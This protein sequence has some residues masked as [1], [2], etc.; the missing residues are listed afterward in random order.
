MD[1]LAEAPSLEPFRYEAQ[2]QHWLAE[3]PDLLEPGLW[4]VAGELELDQVERHRVD[5]LGVDGDGRL[6]VIEVK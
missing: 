3:N 5:L 4:I 6:V 1:H 2:L